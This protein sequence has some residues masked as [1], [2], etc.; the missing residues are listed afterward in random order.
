MTDERQPKEERNHIA[1]EAGQ[2]MAVFMEDPLVQKWFA[3]ERELLM[4]DMMSDPM[5]KDRIQSFIMAIRTLDNLKASMENAVTIAS[6][7]NKEVGND[8]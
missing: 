2:R 7:L 5:D 3:K 8:A 6:R 4:A 1:I